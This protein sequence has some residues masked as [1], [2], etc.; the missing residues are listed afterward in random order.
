M[1]GAP[2]GGRRTDRRSG[3]EK[4]HMRVSFKRILT[5]LGS[6]AFLLLA[7]GAEWKL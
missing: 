2:L 1:L 4:A 3:R 6:L 7:A 5:S